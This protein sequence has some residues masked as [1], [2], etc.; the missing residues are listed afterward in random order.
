MNKQFKKNFMYTWK[1][2][3]AVLQLEKKL[4]GRITLRGILH[5]TDKLFLYLLFSK[6]RVSKIHRSYSRHHT[7]NH[8]SK[9]DIIHAL[10]DWESARYT[11]PDKPETAK[12]YLLGHIPQ[13][14][15]LYEPFLRD[16]GLWGEN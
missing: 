10:I 7:G 2:K 3:I 5:D 8:K 1:H 11:K 4:L 15:K 13:Y 16:L 9:E 14:R 12:Q 6:E